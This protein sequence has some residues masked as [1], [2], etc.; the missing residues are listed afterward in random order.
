MLSDRSRLGEESRDDGL[1]END[2]GEMERACR[3]PLPSSGVM[4][5]ERVDTD[6]D[7]GTLRPGERRCLSGVSSWFPKHGGL[8][9]SLGDECFVPVLLLRSLIRR[10]LDTTTSA[11]SS[12]DRA[13]RGIASRLCVLLATRGLT[14]RSG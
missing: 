9:C 13:N 7:L 12:V 2:R 6:A 4:M 11:S 3:L 1:E 5:R 8:P 10:R 14:A